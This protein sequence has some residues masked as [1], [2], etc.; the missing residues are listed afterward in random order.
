[1]PLEELKKQGLLLPERMWGHRPRASGPDRVSA[2]VTFSLALFAAWLIWVGSGGR[3][4]FI[5]IGIFLVDLFLILLT[6]FRAVNAQ[7]DS[8]EGRG[9][10]GKI[11][12]LDAP[13]EPNEPF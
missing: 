12:G 1:M 2:V 6:T 11:E 3:L 13:T 9:L 8:L 4:T 10:A 5:G 7:V